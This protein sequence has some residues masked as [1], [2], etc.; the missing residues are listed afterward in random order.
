MRSQPQTQVAPRRFNPFFD[1]VD[2]RRRH[3]SVG[4]ILGSFAVGLFVTELRQPSE[5]F[6]GFWMSILDI[7][8][9]ITAFF[10]ACLANRFMYI[11]AATTDAVCLCVNFAGAVLLLEAS[12]SEVYTAGWV[13]MVLIVFLLYHCTS[14]LHDAELCCAA[15]SRGSDE[16]ASSET[17]VAETLE[18]RSRNRAPSPQAPSDF[19]LPENLPTIPTYREVTAEPDALPPNY[20]CI[21]LSLP[22]YTSPHPCRPNA[23]WELFVQHLHRTRFVHSDF[24]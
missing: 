12:K 23:T 13:A 17:P 18:P 1:T 10:C 8:A 11:F 22:E 6:S 20:D 9:T 3:F 19:I 7:C 24:L 15:K 16:T 5:Y 14:C 21:S 4:L 2:N